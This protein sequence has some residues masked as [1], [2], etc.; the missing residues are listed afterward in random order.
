MKNYIQKITPFLWF[1]DN[2]EE[3]A[4]FY[5][6]V[7]SGNSEDVNAG[8]NTK[9]GKITYYNE[10]SAKA[11]GRPVG[12]VMT[13]EFM[14]AG[15]K[16]VALNGGDEFKFSLATSF[17]ISCKSQ[18]EVDYFWEKLSEGGKES[19]CGWIEKDKFGVT[20]QVTPSILMQY[21]NDPDSKKA[22]RVMEAMLKMKKIV[23]A[24][25]EKAYQ[26]N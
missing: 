7:F 18:K 25:L 3:V 4:N 14:L 20:W 2:A 17:M 9:L 12:S 6:S 15:Q 19:V 13:V 11:S 8:K 1:K 26:G 22:L 5:V 21:I 23:I 24:D 10:A 16:F